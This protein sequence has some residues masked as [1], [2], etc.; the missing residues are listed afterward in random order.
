MSDPTPQPPDS[1]PAVGQ[2][3]WVARHA[4]PLLT[5]G[6][7]LAPLE[8]RLR[9]VPWWA[10]LVLFVAVASHLP[11]VSSS[12]YVRRVAFDT[13]LYMLLAL[14]LNV[15]VGW[16]GLLALGYVAFYGVGAYAYALLDSDHFG[17][18]LPTL[19]AVPT[20]VVIGALVGFLVALPS[21]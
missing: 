5:R 15:V 9:R 12:G 3:E 7:F 21:R 10:W 17:I 8:Q 18:H 19:V 11:A 16:G 20:I 1:G 4:A 13:A 6:R 14:G 2:D